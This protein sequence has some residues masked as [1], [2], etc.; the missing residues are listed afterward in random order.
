[1]NHLFYSQRATWDR[2]RSGPLGPH[3]ENFAI[4]LSEQGYAANTGRWKL[5]LVAKLAKTEPFNEPPTRYRPTD[6]L[7]EFLQNL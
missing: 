6:Q 4:H 3:I 7:L 2:L 5:R 1:M